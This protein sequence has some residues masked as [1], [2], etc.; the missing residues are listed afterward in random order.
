M[1]TKTILLNKESNFQV[2]IA[3]RS[4]EAIRADIV[5]AGF[6]MGTVSLKKIIEG[7]PTSHNHGFELATINVPDSAAIVALEVAERS[8]TPK[9]VQP[10]KKAQTHEKLVAPSFGPIEIK[11]VKKDSKTH[12]I[13]KMLCK[14]ATVKEIADE[15]GWTT[16]AVSSVVYWEPKNKGYDLDKEKVEG[17]GNV[18]HLTL[19]GSRV[20]A[21]SLLYTK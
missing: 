16:G 9:K 7:I 10:A 4:L 13:F 3:S 18:L 19:N 8:Q 15:F 1:K 5:S 14:G 2:E 20:K 12:K 21:K 17:R 11:P 6:V